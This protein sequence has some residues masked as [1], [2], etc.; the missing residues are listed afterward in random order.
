[1]AVQSHWFSVGSIVIWAEAGVGAVAT[2]SMIEMSYGPLGLALMRAGKSPAETLAALTSVDNEHELRQV[3]MVDRRGRV[4]VHT[5]RRCVA[6]AG[7]EIGEGF[8]AQAI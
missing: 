4:A 8:S 6:D 1:M 3:A 5:G 2:Q 7:H